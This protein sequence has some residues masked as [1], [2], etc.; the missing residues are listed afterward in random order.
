M[1]DRALG[2][3]IRMQFN[4]TNPDG[5]GAPVAPSSAFVVA[6]IR[7]YKDGSAT[8]KA[9]TNGL[10]VTSPF[11]SITGLHLVEI[12]TSNSTGDVGFWASGSVYHVRLV[13]AT[14]VATYSVSGLLIGEFSIELQTADTRKFNGTAITAAAGIPEVKV[15]S[16]AANAVNASALAADAVTE[17]QAGLASQTS[18]D[19]L[20][21]NAELATAL[22]TADDAVLAAIATVQS[23]T[24]DIQTRLPA[25]L[26]SGRIAAAL[27]SGVT[28]QLDA[29]EAAI[30]LLRVSESRVVERSLSDTNAITFAWPVSGA[31]ITATRSIDN[32]TYGAVQGAIAFL[33]TESSKH[34]YTL[35]FDADDRP[36]AEG[37]VRYKFEDGTYTRY[38]VVRVVSQV[39][40]SQ[41]N[42]EVLD[43]LNV[44]TF[45]ELAS[46]PA[47]TSSLRAKLTW[48]FM[49]VR[50]KSTET[51]IERK[52]YADDTT[53]VVS[54]EGVSDDGTT[55]T[56]DEAV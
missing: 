4:S 7:I 49:W 31:T 2:S 9:T 33:R 29:M 52:L 15:A 48:L 32:G 47:A 1:R 40:T 34:Y 42:A 14:T 44:D 45:A 50:N 56:K 37:Q 27:D 24:N 21:T 11:D 10:T 22:G 3:T 30:A 51:A 28:D 41:V 35:A 16:I 20:P 18:V 25:A 17:I 8:E 19:D 23:D 38:V 6:D 5:G 55:F 12:D 39:T 46:P 53:T 43:V 36:A 54:T 13:T 26:E